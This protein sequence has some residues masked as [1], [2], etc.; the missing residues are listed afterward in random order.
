MT[1]LGTFIVTVQF[2]V[3][4]VLR[5]GDVLV[6]VNTAALVPEAGS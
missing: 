6:A 4:C 5:L 1:V 3:N 2:V